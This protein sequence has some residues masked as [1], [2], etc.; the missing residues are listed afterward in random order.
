MKDNLDCNLFL[1]NMLSNMIALS[2]SEKR[3]KSSTKD[4]SFSAR[5]AYLTAGK[6][7]R[8]GGSGAAWFP[9]NPMPAV[10]GGDT[11]I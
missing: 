9:Q 2:V 6:E 10:K 4:P 1:Q 5:T 8:S 7:G 11:D 3:V